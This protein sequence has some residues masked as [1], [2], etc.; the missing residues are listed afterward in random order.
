MDGHLR[1]G[2]GGGKKGEFYGSDYGPV[3]RRFFCI[4]SFFYGRVVIYRVI[5][6]AESD[7]LH[8]RVQ[9]W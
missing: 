9:G 4:E 2:Y 5:R 6:A 3:P 7:L 1:A 8:V